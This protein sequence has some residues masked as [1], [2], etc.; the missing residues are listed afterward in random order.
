[1]ETYKVIVLGSGGVGKS[2]ITLQLVQNRFVMAYD[3]TIEDSYKKTI[4]VDGVEINLD[5][6]DTAG[7]DDFKPLRATHMR[8]GQGFL[9][10]FALNDLPSFD[11]VDRIQSDIRATCEHDEV[12]IVVCGN[13]SDLVSDRTVKKDD[14]EKFCTECRLTYFETSSKNNVN[15]TEAFVDLARKMRRQNPNIAKAQD[16][17]QK[18]AGGAAP[19]GGC[20]SVA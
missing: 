6:L 11:S 4:T 20:C 14:A 13:K 9:V 2:A 19:G 7:Q 1:M 8:T 15:V 18:A 3:P 10:V 16:A 12:P 17:Q 5:I